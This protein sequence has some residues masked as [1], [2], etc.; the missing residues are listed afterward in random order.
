MQRLPS[1]SRSLQRLVSAHKLSD[2]SNQVPNSVQTPSERDVTLSPASLPR[3]VQIICEASATGPL[4]SYNAVDDKCVK[5]LTCE[6]RKSLGNLI[7]RG[8][9]TL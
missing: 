8:I 2:S 9:Y 6:W 3:N 1:F 4:F 7:F 5:K